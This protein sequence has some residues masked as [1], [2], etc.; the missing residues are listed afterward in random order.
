[1]KPKI[2]TLILLAVTGGVLGFVGLRPLIQWC[3]AQDLA[4]GTLVSTTV[5]GP[6][7]FQLTGAFWGGVLGAGIGCAI[8]MRSKAFA[9]FPLCAYVS[10]GLA[11][12]AMMALKIR[13]D[14]VAALD[15]QRSLGYAPLINV[16]YVSLPKIT[17]AGI[18]AVIL[19]AA[20]ERRMRSRRT[21][22]TDSSVVHR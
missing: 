21:V 2:I 15:M 10:L 4:H 3:A 1:V 14:V 20:L 22:V 13:R 5:V 8:W 12:S 7:M 19:V 11:A 17:F 6:L 18:A 9:I 16:E